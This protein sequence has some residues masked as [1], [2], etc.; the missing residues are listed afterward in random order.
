MINYSNYT[1]RY[2][3]NGQTFTFSIFAESPSEAKQ[4]L[5]A[6]GKGWVEKHIST[7]RKWWKFWR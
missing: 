4:I 7:P 5:K 3:H 2:I 6:M 1:V